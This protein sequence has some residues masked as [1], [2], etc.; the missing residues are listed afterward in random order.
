[1]ARGLPCTSEHFTLDTH[2]L[3]HR[4]HQAA[5]AALSAM[6]PSANAT[7]ADE[8]EIMRSTSEVA[9]NWPCAS[10]S[11]RE[12]RSTFSSE[13]A[14]LMVPQPLGPSITL[15]HH[16][17][18]CRVVPHNKIRRPKTAVGQRQRSTSP[19][20]R[21]L[22]SAVPSIAAIAEPKRS[23][24]GAISRSP[25]RRGQAVS[26]GPCRPMVASY[27]KIKPNRKCT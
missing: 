9:F 27:L 26:L 18:I 14:Q 19:P 12:S 6:V 5:V 10:L 11:S 24:L 23:L 8:L 4:S 15:P 21:F 22:T 20:A 13:K 17:R 3:S 25:R 1:M 7:S 2:G 16:C